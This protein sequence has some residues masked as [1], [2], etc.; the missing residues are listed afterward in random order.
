MRPA[1]EADEVGDEKF[2]SPD[3]AV[4]AIAGSVKG[5]AD[6]LAGE[7]VL[8]HATGDVRV[9]VLH[10]DFRFQR[11]SQRETRAHVLWM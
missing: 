2:A 7:M 5:H 3:F 8:R 4:G 6:D 11:Q 9:M 10:A 1:L